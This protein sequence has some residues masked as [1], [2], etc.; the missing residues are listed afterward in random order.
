MKTIYEEVMNKMFDFKGIFCR[1]LGLQGG[2][3]VS[4]TGMMMLLVAALLVLPSCTGDDEV[5]VP[6]PT[7][8]VCADGST[9]DSKDK[10]P[11]PPD[12]PDPPDYDET[13]KSMWNGGDG[14]DKVSG[15]S[16]ND[17]LSGGGGDDKLNGMDGDDTLNGDGDDDMLIGGDGNDTIDGGAGN[18][19]IDGGAGNDMITGSG[20]D[21]TIDGGTGTD[22]AKYVKTGK[23]N[24]ARDLYG[25]DVSLKTGA[26]QNQ[27]DGLGGRDRLSN[28]ENLECSSTATMDTSTDDDTQIPSPQTLSVKFVGDDN[29]NVLTGCD[30]DDTLTG[31]GGDDT[32]IGNGGADMLD[33]GD[34][35]DTASYAGSTAGVT[36]DLSA[37]AVE[38]YITVA[39]TAGTTDDD[40]KIKTAGTGDDEKSTVENVTGGSGIDTITGDGQDNV[41]KGG[42]ET[43][44][45]GA[46]TAG[47]TL[48]GGDGNDTLDGEAGNDTLNGGDGD[49]KLTGGAGTD[50]LN[51]DAGNDTLDGG[52]GADDLIGGAGND[53][54]MNVEVGDSAD[55]F[56]TAEAA[57]TAGGEDT[58]KYLNKAKA[59][60][61]DTTTGITV[62][63]SPSNV[64]MVYV[65]RYDDTVTA[66]D[67]GAT[68]YGLEGDDTLNGG[69]EQDTLWGCAGKDTLAGGAESDTFVI[70]METGNMDT[71]SDY[72]A[73][74]TVLLAGFA[75]GATVTISTVQNSVT[76]AAIM[77]N[78]KM[79]ASVG[80]A[81]IVAPTS[82]TDNPNPTV[83]DGIVAELK[84]TD[85]S[86]KS[87]VRFDSSD[88]MECSSPAE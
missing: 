5:E 29:D 84:K 20:G 83:A 11:A 1:R 46:S 79:V 78:N 6:G 8:Y 59:A 22:T 42:D 50:T 18:D 21:D 66:P 63:T 73:G 26:T 19:T 69:A 39:A 80:T 37:A 2:R 57:G 52:A 75:D 15:T 58:I 27:N 7:K 72:A 30:G 65:T 24:A 56:S 48:N 33:G 44:D 85:T 82:T 16:G 36:I 28:I 17:T 77:V 68:I 67:S 32:L 23:N 55:T 13:N 14:V 45:A 53:T 49:D 40:D 86:G 62:N 41:L 71:I 88:A 35:S 81:T 12:P 34:G 43:D 54:Y 87:L 61:D 60:S 64:E 31:N 38:G 51:G 70:S 10:C 47:D 74:E 4:L 25:T 3:S 76:L 9:V